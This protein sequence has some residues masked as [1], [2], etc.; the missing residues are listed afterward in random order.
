V[1][2]QQQQPL[3]LPLVVV[4]QYQVVVAQYQVVAATNSH[5]LIKIKVYNK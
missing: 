3:L 5:I 4:A 2:L 1:P